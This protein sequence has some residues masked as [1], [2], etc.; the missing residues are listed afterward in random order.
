[1]SLESFG[2]K[3]K[4]QR[5]LKPYYSPQTASNGFNINQPK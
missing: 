5:K 4:A 1:M 2:Q 3:N